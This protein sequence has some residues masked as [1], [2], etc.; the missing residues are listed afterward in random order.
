MAIDKASSFGAIT[1]HFNI[2]AIV[3]GVGTLA[4]VLSLV[5][6]S[7]KP[8]AQNRADAQ[9]EDADIVASAYSGNTAAAIEEV[10]CTYALKSGSLPFTELTIGELAAQIFASSIAIT[11]ANGAWPQIVVSGFLGLETMT[12]PASKT[13]KFTLPA[14]TINGVKQAQ[15]M[16]FTIAAGGRLIGSGITFNCEMAEQADGLGEP[17]AHGVSGGTGEV[18]AEFVKVEASQPDWTLAASLTGTTFLAEVTQEPG[19]D[20]GQAAWHTTSAAAQFILTR[21]AA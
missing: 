9:N 19:A 5:A 16:G 10:S 1:D 21:T 18:T 4:D 12:A 20:E 13:N 8:R 7:R 15:L 2:L 6:S 3:H 11:T 14:I 17:V